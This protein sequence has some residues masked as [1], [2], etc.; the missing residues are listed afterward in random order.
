MNLNPVDW[1]QA[2][3]LLVKLVQVLTPLTERIVPT[4]FFLSRRFVIPAGLMQDDQPSIPLRHPVR[5]LSA[6]H[7]VQK[8]VEELIADSPQEPEGEVKKN[9]SRPAVKNENVPK[10]TPP[11]S[12]QAQKLIVQVQDA[13]GK[14]ATSTYIQDPQEAPLRKALKELK[15]D[16]DRIIDLMV[17]NP[18]LERVP[19]TSFRHSIPRSPREHLL[20][21]LTAFPTTVP[22]ENR[23]P[24]EVLSQ[25]ASTPVPVIRKEAVHSPTQ[26]YVPIPRAVQSIVEKERIEPK[27]ATAPAAA[28][29]FE[30]DETVAPLPKKKD[31]SEK[32]EVKEGRE[33]NRKSSLEREKHPIDQDMEKQAPVAGKSETKP[34][35]KTFEAIALPGAPFISQPKNLVEH[36]KKKKRRG[37]WFKGED[38]SDADDRNNS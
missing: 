32:Q 20:E 9:E 35:T 3:D 26:P 11:L 12:K 14:L 29:S 21:K 33:P 19:P 27:E 15:P 18:E 8:Q 2:Q 36:K 24:A 13:I 28:L 6:L 37:F 1:S 5:L 17:Q 4:S 22:R 38:D 7:T 10:D 16:L 30:K 34:A 31:L 25:P 23:L